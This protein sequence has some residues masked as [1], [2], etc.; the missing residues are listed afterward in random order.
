MKSWLKYIYG[1]FIILILLIIYFFI[2][3]NLDNI[4]DVINLSIINFL[5]LSILILITIT[6][7]GYK[8]NILSE[9]YNIK[10]KSKEWFGLS[11]ITTMSN[12]LTPFGLG[13]SLRGIYLK[14]KYKLPYKSFITTLGINFIVS[15]FMYGFIGISLMIF[16]NFKYNFFSFV[17]FSIF[18]VMFIANLL[19]ILFSP[20]LKYTKY[21]FLNNFIYIVNEW[22]RIKKD[23]KLATKLVLN[24]F[25]ALINYSLRISF[26]FFILSNKI[27]FLFS[28]LIALLTVSSLIIGITP[29]SLG[30]K[31]ILITYSTIAIGK[32]LDLG[33]LVAAIDRG[34]AILYVFLLGGIFS[35]ILLKNLKKTKKQ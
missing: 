12:Y 16:F 7:N 20:S 23:W 34:V 32:T 31:E 35:Y 33:I 26:I 18:L 9:Y 28:V 22:R 11:V 19:I 21:K 30:I 5:I 1:I 25:L 6:L 24:D 17:I 13:T 2:K 8:I 4:K 27:P 14:K 15:F 3:N 29:A 10:L